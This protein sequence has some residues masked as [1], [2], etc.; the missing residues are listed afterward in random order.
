VTDQEREDSSYSPLRRDDPK[1][2]S[3]RIVVFQYLAVAVLLYLISGFWELQ[4]RNPEFYS[5]QADRNRIKALPVPAPRG[6]ILDR[7]GRVIVD[8]HSSFSLILSRENLRLEHVSQIADGLQLDS[9]ELLTRL[10]RFSSRPRYE[11][12]TIKEELTG[13][14]LA[15]VEAH[16]GAE[17]YPEMELI[18]A[19]RRLYP[20]EGLA[21]HVIGYAGEV[22]DA[23]LN[24]AEFA[25]YNLGETVGKAGVERQY[26]EI[27]TGI[28]GQRQVVVD[29][30][31][32]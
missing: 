22:S 29:N 30:R 6:K 32:S 15:F 20:R 9:A 19:Q 2:A 23:E 18:H 11:P 14:E 17:G 13:G 5:E 28:D 25:K 27:L 10:K 24:T 16:R 8:N 26:N 21:A 1:F 31:G 4:V 7:D 3:T 12:I